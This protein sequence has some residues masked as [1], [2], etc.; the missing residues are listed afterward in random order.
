MKLFQPFF[1]VF[2][3]AISTFAI[4]PG[5]ARYVGGTVPGTTPGVVG[6]MNTTSETA[7]TFEYAGNTVAI[8]YAS[9]ESFK[10]TKEPTVHLGV[11][12]AIVVGML[13]SR[14]H[15]HF[16]RISYR[17]P[18]GVMQVA[19]FE[20]PKHEPPIIRAILN[21]RAPGTDKTCGCTNGE[22]H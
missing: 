22:Q 9:V 8:P 7:L 14:Q 12:P 11:L 10:Y 20:V 13:K 16:F 5:H 2:L 21:S 17:G 19:V 1:V 18:S 15:R 6:R 3:F 4:D